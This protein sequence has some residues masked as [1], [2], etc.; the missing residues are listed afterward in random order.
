MYDKEVRY[1]KQNIDRQYPAIPLLPYAESTTFCNFSV[2]PIDFDTPK[3][4]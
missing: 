2:K 3:E 1:Q 4:I